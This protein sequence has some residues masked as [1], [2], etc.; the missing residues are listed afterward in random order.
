M[1]AVP[2]GGKQSVKLRQQVFGPAA[3]LDKFGAIRSLYPA[4]DRVVVQTPEQISQIRAEIKA[5]QKIGR[6]RR[7]TA[8]ITDLTEVL[9]Y[10]TDLKILP[11]IPLQKGLQLGNQK[12]QVRG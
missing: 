11:F 9:G 4:L 7:A 8:V 3:F 10:G 2:C 6:S 1:L 12:S 5:V